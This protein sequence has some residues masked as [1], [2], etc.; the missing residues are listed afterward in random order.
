MHSVEL[1]TPPR[2]QDLFR[3]AWIAK[4]G[5]VYA[6]ADTACVN[7]VDRLLNDGSSLVVYQ[8]SLA[9]IANNFLAAVPHHPLVVC[10]LNLAVNSVLRGDRDIVWLSTGPGLLTR[11]FVQDWAVDNG[12]WLRHVRVLTSAEIQRVLAPNAVT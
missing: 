7:S 3:L 4:Y 2:R 5:G 6:D 1:L 10:A 12:K 8:E 11:V 9:S